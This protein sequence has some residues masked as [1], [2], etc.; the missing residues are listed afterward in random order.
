MCYSIRHVFSTLLIISIFH[1][2]LIHRVTQADVF[3]FQ[4][5][6]LIACQFQTFCFLKC[7]RSIL[8]IPCKLIFTYLTFP[9]HTRNALMYFLLSSPSRIGYTLSL[10]DICLPFPASSVLGCVYL[11]VFLCHESI[12][13]S[14][15]SPFCPSFVTEFSQVYYGP[16]SF[17]ISNSY[18][19]I[20]ITFMTVSLNVNVSTLYVNALKT[21]LKA[22]LLRQMGISELRT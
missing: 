11:V 14:T 7:W 6:Y 16:V 9:H 20:C 22:F 10:L 19:Y 15:L 4:K 3:N 1:H 21:H 17:K 13:V 18:S 8:E 5:L 2:S 12:V